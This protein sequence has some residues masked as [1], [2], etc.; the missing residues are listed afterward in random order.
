M[1]FNKMP[2]WKKKTHLYRPAVA[3]PVCFFDVKIIGAGFLQETGLTPFYIL[4]INVPTFR[5]AKQV[6]PF[7][8]TVIRIAGSRHV[9]TCY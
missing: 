7:T 8:T 6:P 5:V 1:C 9:R 3:G 2:V 4:Y